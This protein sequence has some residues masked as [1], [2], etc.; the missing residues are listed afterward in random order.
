MKSRPP[1]GSEAE[2]TKELGIERCSGFLSE[3]ALYLFQRA[4]SRAVC[5]LAFF[6]LCG[7]RKQN[8]VLQVYVL[9]QILFECDER[10]VQRLVTDAGV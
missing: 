6:H 8:V 10:F 9:V 7:S 3:T 1:N 2:F 4:R 5:S